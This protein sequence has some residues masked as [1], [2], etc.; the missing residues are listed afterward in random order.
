MPFLICEEPLLS[1]SFSLVWM[2]R[3]KMSKLILYYNI[4]VKFLWDGLGFYYYVKFSTAG[5]LIHPASL[6]GALKP[7]WI[8]GDDCGHPYAGPFTG[9]NFRYTHM[10]EATRDSYPSQNL[11]RINLYIILLRYLSLFLLLSTVGNKL[12]NNCWE[13]EKLENF[14]YYLLFKHINYKYNTKIKCKVLIEDVVP[15]YIL[16]FWK[17]G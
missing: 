9:E 11:L 8:Y 4:V 14:H 17:S 13:N 12:Y 3:Y 16:S 2:L 10:Q 15:I 1:C 6:C 5:V 7:T